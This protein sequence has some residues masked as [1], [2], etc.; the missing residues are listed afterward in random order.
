MPITKDDLLA[1]E[2]FGETKAN[3]YG[4]DIVRIM[5]KY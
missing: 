4:L 2:G 5:R 3:K 1:V